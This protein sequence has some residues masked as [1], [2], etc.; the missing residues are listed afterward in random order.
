M[1][2]LGIGFD[3]EQGYF[4][5]LC[6]IVHVDQIDRSYWILAHDL[7]RRPFISV[8]PHD[9]NRASDGLELREEYLREIHYPKYIE[10]EGECSVL[11]ML[12]GLARRMDFETSD[13]YDICDVTDR[14]A[15]WFWEMIDNLGLLAFSDD[16]YVD[17]GGMTQADRAID[18]LL[19][20]EYSWNG[21]GGLFPLEKTNT[22]Q[23][24]VELWYQMNAYL[25]ERDLA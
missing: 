15:Y 20:R 10:I 12:I 1:N 3:I 14:T 22:D 24:D 8:I 6:D 23:R 9:E 17:Y 16:C 21:E 25:M 4:E 13:P 2:N 18:R 19:E 5:Y 7:Y 11:E